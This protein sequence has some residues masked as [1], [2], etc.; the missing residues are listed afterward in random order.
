MAHVLAGVLTFETGMCLDR[1]AESGHALSRVE[2]L[3]LLDMEGLNN[4]PMLSW[5]YFRRSHAFTTSGLKLACSKE[6]GQELTTT[7]FA[8]GLWWHRGSRGEG[9]SALLTVPGT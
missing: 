1:I 3:R 8:Q 9:S 5:T 7:G 4:D 2:V 6:L